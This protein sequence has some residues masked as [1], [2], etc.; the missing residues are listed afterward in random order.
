MKIW[1][2]SR[3]H[4]IITTSYKEAFDKFATEFNVSSFD[5]STELNHFKPITN[6]FIAYARNIVE[7]ICNSKA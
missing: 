6:E 7:K 5:I 4:G 3:G 1:L 2:R